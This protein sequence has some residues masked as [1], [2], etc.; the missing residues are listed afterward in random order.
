VEEAIPESRM[1]SHWAG[2]NTLNNQSIVVKASMVTK[3]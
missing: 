3:V 2:R 1:Q